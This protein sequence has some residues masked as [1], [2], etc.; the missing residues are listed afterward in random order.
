MNTPSNSKPNSTLKLYTIDFH[1]VY[2]RLPALAMAVANSEEEALE[3][4]LL[5]LAEECPQLL[6]ENIDSIDSI[7]VT[8]NGRLEEL[9]NTCFILTH[10]D[11]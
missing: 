1:G 4:F 6:K 7:A 5:R 9:N 10:G 8:C 2:S 3:A 11:D